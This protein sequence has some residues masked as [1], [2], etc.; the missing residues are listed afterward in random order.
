MKNRFI[1]LSLSLILLTAAF[2]EMNAQKS[3]SIGVS[4]GIGFLDDFEFAKVG[5]EFN[6]DVFDH[7]RFT[8][9]LDYYISSSSYLSANA[10]FSYVIGI[11]EKMEFFPI[12]GIAYVTGGNWIGDTF[13][14]NIGLGIQYDLKNDFALNA[15]LKYQLAGDA[16]VM[17]LG[18]GIV[19]KF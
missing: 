17:V 2:S 12:L 6:W 7:V 8:P 10:D 4:T 15:K 13:G 1:F 11:A 16:D 19:K 14:A 3:K 9:S 18:V 5:A